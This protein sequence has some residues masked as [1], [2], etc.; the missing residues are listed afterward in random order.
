MQHKRMQ[1]N[2]ASLNKYSKAR[3]NVAHLKLIFHNIG[4]TLTFGGL[5]QENKT[6]MTFVLGVPPVCR[7]LIFHS[8]LPIKMAEQTAPVALQ[9]TAVK[10]AGFSYPC[11]LCLT[12]NTEEFKAHLL[13]GRKIRR[14]GTH[15]LEERRP[16]VCVGTIRTSSVSCVLRRHSVQAASRTLGLLRGCQSHFVR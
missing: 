8:T 2:F 5:F 15:A 13:S 11:P 14:P 10:V 1:Y 6:M 16:D 7:M 9:K 12:L 3:K 4:Q